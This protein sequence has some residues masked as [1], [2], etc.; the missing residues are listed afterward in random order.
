MNTQISLFDEQCACMSA[1]TENELNMQ[2]LDSEG[3]YIIVCILAHAQTNFT[4]WLTVCTHVCVR[5][6]ISGWNQFT[7]NSNIH[8]NEQK[9]NALWYVNLE[10]TGTDRKV[11]KSI[12]R[13]FQGLQRR[14]GKIQFY[15]WLCKEK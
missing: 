1:C 6:S 8:N 4:F 11:R 12:H 14:R 3:K 15:G 2:N 13:H 9:L 7:T 5:M 10:L